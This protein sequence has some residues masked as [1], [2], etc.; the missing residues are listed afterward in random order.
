MTIDTKDGKISIREEL[1]IYIEEHKNRYFFP[2][3]GEFEAYTNY[4]EL[5]I[6]MVGKYIDK[7]DDQPFPFCK[8][9]K[10]NQ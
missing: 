2:Y 4:F 5:E 10:I 3:D 6:K 8:F 1:L 7:L 9:L